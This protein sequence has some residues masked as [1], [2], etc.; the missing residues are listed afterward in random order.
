MCT[1]LV[2]VFPFLSPLFY[3]LVLILSFLL[4]WLSGK[5]CFCVQFAIA[6]AHAVVLS[7][8]PPSSFFFSTALIFGVTRKK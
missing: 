8:L 6:H 2:P 7:F 1:V 4:P 3:S 5:N